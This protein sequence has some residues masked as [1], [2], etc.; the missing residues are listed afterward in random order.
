M[1]EKINMRQSPERGF[2]YTDQPPPERL[3]GFDLQ[4][5][6]ENYLYAL[7]RIQ[8]QRDVIFSLSLVPVLAGVGFVVGFLWSYEV[9][10]WINVLGFLLAGGMYLGLRCLQP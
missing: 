7:W 8:Q 5:L 3:D 4:R 6:E 10:F 2:M 1:E 9:G